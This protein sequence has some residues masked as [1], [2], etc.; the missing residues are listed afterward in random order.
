M[1]RRIQEHDEKVFVLLNDALSGEPTTLDFSMSQVRWMCSNVRICLVC[2]GSLC[3][4]SVCDQQDAKA[5]CQHG[6]RIAA[7]MGR[8][9]LH[10]KRYKESV[11]ALTL[12]KCFR[13]HLWEDARFLIRQLPGV[14]HVTA[15][16]Y[17]YTH[18][19][20]FL[21]E[22]HYQV[23]V[24][25]WFHTAFFNCAHSGPRGFWYRHIYEAQDIRCKEIGG[26]NWAKVSIW[27]PD[28]DNARCPSTSTQ[29]V[30]FS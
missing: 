19:V 3:L 23:V 30:H 7:C 22:C 20:F 24:Q 14:G 17:K 21:F 25:R 1:K 6:A 15:K 5:I 2:D 16:V 28:Q 12:T 8:Y 26:C 29:L 10:V 27:E 4:Y 13:Q 9:F 18:F 11:A